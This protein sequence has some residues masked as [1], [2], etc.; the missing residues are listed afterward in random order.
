MPQETPDPHSPGNRHLLVRYAG[1]AIQWFAVLL[2]SVYLGKKA[3]AWFRFSKPV[4]IWLL[5]VAGILGML[6]G[7]IRDT[8]PR[9]K[10]DR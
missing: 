1:M 4:F 6:A 9:K 5:P 3:D 8:K 2:A 7:V 10:N